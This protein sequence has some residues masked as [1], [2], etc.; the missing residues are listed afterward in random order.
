MS[1][2]RVYR[3]LRYGDPI[4]VV[5]GLPRSGTSMAMRMLAAGGVP[6]VMD[7]R[8]AA[9]EDNPN[10]YFEDERV[11]N[12]VQS[13]D[14]RW[15]QDARGKA[16]KIIAALL[17]NVPDA[18]NY[19]I[20]F[21]HRNLHE[22]LA[23][24]TKMLARRGEPAGP[25]D[26]KLLELF[27][28]HLKSGA[29]RAIGMGTARRVPAAPDIPTFVEQGLPGYV[30]EAWFAV[31]GPKGMA[32]ADVKRAHDAVVAAFADPAVKDSMD[33]Q[34]NV[35]NVSSTDFAKDFFKTEL[36]KYA[37]LVKKAGVEAQ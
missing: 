16:I 7:G 9:D 23:S 37:N 3:R 1:F 30:V 11:K 34:G 6:L 35:I 5:S 14:K 32:A 18:N 29:L 4:I 12:L 2:Q 26:E 21:L 20:L 31:I 28:Q 24:Q 22:V 13:P 19:K 33:K 36:V 8:R 27:Q 25:S 17:E 10:G 15:L